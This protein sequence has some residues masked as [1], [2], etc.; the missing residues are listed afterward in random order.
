[1]ELIIIICVVWGCYIFFRRSNKKT[2]PQ[3]QNKE[4]LENE[5]L[6]RNIRQWGNDQWSSSIQWGLTSRFT[7]PDNIPGNLIV[8]SPPTGTGR[9]FL[10]R[11]GG[12]SWG[13]AATWGTYDSNAL[14]PQPYIY[15]RGDNPV[16]WGFYFTLSPFSDRVA[17][18]ES[19][20][21]ELSQA[22]YNYLVLI[23]KQLKLLSRWCILQAKTNGI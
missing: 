12:T 11:W 16:Y 15:T 19:E 7:D 22:E 10:Y 6:N 4:L 3:K 13:S 5:V 17:I 9:I 1:M 20:F 18:D 21:L 8:G 23:I 14:N 2:P